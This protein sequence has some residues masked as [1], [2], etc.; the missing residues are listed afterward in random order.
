MNQDSLVGVENRQWQEIFLFSITSR[1]SL[2]PTKSIIQW[3]S[4]I[5]S[6]GVK[7]QVH[8]ADYLPPSSAK[9]KNVAAIPP[10]PC[11]SS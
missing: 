11:M 9:I 3:V 2:G 1:L 6:P 8:E 5:F 7:Q 10:L 4:G